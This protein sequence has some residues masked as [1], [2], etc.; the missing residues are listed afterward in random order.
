[1]PVELGEILEGKVTGITNFGAFVA[2]PDGKTG[3]IHISEIAE[4]YVRDINDFLKVNDQVKVKVIS[5]DP[6]GKIG[7]SIKQAVE[8]RRK[9]ARPA[10][11]FEEKLSRFLKDSDERLQALRRS[12][13]AKRGGRG[14]GRR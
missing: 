7:L 13:D 6:K 9:P 1:M 4:E 2:L 10:L 11:S 3:L 8:R 5:V 12:T 14:A